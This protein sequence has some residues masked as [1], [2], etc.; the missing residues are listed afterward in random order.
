VRTAALLVKNFVLSGSPSKTGPSPDIRLGLRENWE[1]FALLV[2]VNGFVGAMVGLERSVLPV[3]GQ[4]GFELVSRTAI[5]SFLITFGTFK[6]A[7]NYFAGDLSGRIGRKPVLLLGW[8][9]ALPV[10]FMIIFAPSWGWVVAANALLGVNKDLAW[11]TTVIMKI[12]LLGPRRRGL[13]MG[14]NEAAGYVSVSL[15]ALTAGYLAAAYGARPAPFLLG[16]GFAVAG[17]LLTLFFVRETREHAEF[18][19]T[20]NRASGKDRGTTPGSR[21]V[22]VR[23]SFTDRNL[24]SASQAGLVNNLND[25]VAWGLFPLFF[26]SAGLSVSRIGI[27]AALYP[28]VWGMGQL[29]TGWAS[30][31]LGRKWMIAFG[32]WIQASGILLTA[33]TG[34]FAPWAFGAVLMGLG[35]AL[36]YPTLLAAIGDVAHPSW[37]VSSVGVYRLWRDLSYAISAVVVGVM[38]DLF[39]FAQAIAAVGARGGDT[40]ARDAHESPE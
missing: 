2:V 7:A 32:M 39:G 31:R 6:P 13:A 4:E 16:V 40:D 1:Q 11:S 29:A 14:L 3:L 9:A 34:S 17:L 19:A 21:E 28:A 38:A 10:P 8:L 24:S 35:T 22:S 25:G 33:A 23:T 5:L 12:D 15:A 18:E 20:Q 26:A 27:L 30:D 37:R 36:V